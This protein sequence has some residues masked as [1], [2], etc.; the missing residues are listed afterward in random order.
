MSDP[1]RA[2]AVGGGFECVEVVS[3]VGFYFGPLPSV[4]ALADVL[5]ALCFGHSLVLERFS[6]GARFESL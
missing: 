1:P 6:D 4:E 2:F 5:Y 3:E